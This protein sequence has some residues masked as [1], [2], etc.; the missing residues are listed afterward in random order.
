M[1]VG[2][3]LALGVGFAL[4]QQRWG[5]IR[6]AGEAFLMEAYPVRIEAADLAAVGFGVLLLGTAIG[7]ATAAGVIGRK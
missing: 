2:L 5:L 7:A 6:M 1:G 4:A 3:G